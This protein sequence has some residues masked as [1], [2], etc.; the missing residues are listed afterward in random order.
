[1]FPCQDQIEKPVFLDV[2]VS[3]ILDNIKSFL[4]LIWVQILLVL[5]EGIYVQPMSYFASC[6]LHFSMSVL[7][8]YDI[9]R[10][11]NTLL[12]QHRNKK[13]AWC[14]SLRIEKER[15]QEL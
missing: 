1:M 9:G 10:C 3:A 6:N 4:K 12:C 7:I 14:H 15:L 5:N 2:S 11:N 13:H 8:R